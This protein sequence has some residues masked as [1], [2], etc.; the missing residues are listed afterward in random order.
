MIYVYILEMEQICKQSPQQEESQ[1]DK[2]EL[3]ESLQLQNISSN[4]SITSPFQLLTPTPINSSNQHAT[5]QINKAI[6][7][8]MDENLLKNQYVQEDQ[9]QSAATIKYPPRVKKA[10][11]KKMKRTVK[12]QIGTSNVHER[13]VQALSMS[14]LPANS[15]ADDK[16]G[17]PLKPGF[18]LFPWYK[19]MYSYILLNIYKYV[20][21]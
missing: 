4:Q 14:S 9:E 13:T 10:E 2:Q 16:N 3:F 15:Y 20:H 21:I 11:S 7:D 1:Q 6:V 17:G 8:K 19:Y 18:H 5:T 12:D